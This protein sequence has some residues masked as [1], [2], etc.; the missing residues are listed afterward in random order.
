MARKQAIPS[1]VR[2]AV[3]ERDGGDCHWCGRPGRIL[4]HGY[5]TWIEHEFDHV[6]PESRGGA[7]SAD[8]IVIACRACN[9]SRGSKLVEE[10]VPCRS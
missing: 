10:W 7:T 4:L 8:N 3:V 2:R 5:W 1:G 9:R 6:L